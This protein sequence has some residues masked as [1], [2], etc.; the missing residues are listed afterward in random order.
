MILLNEEA[1]ISH[2]LR[3]PLLVDQDRFTLDYSVFD[4]LDTIILEGLRSTGVALLHKDT[5]R[6]VHMSYD[7][8]PMIAFWTPGHK[9]A[10][11]IC[12]EPWHGL[13][14]LADETGNFEDRPYVTLLSPGMSHQCGYDV[15]LI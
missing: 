8:F 13:P 12:L 1:L 14:S 7:G 4:R 15:E 6:G 5:G 11:F 2:T 10:P 3:E 9:K